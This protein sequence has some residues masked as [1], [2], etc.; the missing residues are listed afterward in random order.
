MAQPGP[1]RHSPAWHCPAQLGSARFGPAVGT[2]GI[3]QLTARL[4]LF[5]PASP[6]HV[7]V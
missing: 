5:P 3:A 7:V 1:A 2:L 6:S 4:R